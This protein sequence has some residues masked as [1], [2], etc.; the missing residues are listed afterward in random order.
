MALAGKR[1][2]GWLRGWLPLTFSRRVWALLII[3]FVL[4]GFGTAGYMWLAGWSFSDALFMTAITLTTVGF[5]EVRP[6]D[7]NGRLFTILLILLGA[8]YLAFGLV[9]VRF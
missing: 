7:D 1:V 2:K 3:P 4:F 5:G 9:I 8:F 6:L